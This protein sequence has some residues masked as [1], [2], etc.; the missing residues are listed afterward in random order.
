MADTNFYQ[1]KDGK[2]TELCKTCLTAHINNWEPET[3]L[4]LLEKFDVP[5]I[6][7]EWN[8]LRDRAY[9]KDP[10]KFG[11]MSVFGKYLSKMKLNQWK[12]FTWA[13]TEKL[14][15]EAE[16]KAKLYGSGTNQAKSDFDNIKE[17]YENGEISEAQYQTYAELNK[18]EKEFVFDEVTKQV[19]EKG[20]ETTAQY[21]INNHPFE[22]V[23]LPDPTAEL[24]QEDKIYLAMKWGQ[25]YSAADWIKLEEQYIDYEKSFDLHNA[26][27]I[28][29]TKELCKLD[30]KGDQALDTGDFDSYSKIARAKDTLRKSLKFTEAQRKEDKESEFSCYGQI[31][32]FAEENNDEDYIPNIDLSVDR[33]MVDI[34]IRDMKNYTKTLIEDDPAVFKM[35]EQY[36]KK[37]EILAEQERD[38]EGLEDGEVYELSDEEMSEYNQNIEQQRAEDDH[39][40]KE[41]EEDD[42]E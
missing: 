35:I 36:I 27:L 42:D 28:R 7:A 38:A 20:T 19:V 4:W 16:E 23:D 10:V 33:D 8:V 1:Y 25:L 9:N 41:E 13:D 30:L 34:D 11:P 31:V 26:D 17:A 15:L 39:Y 3:F 21:P 6:E 22:V 12:N 24:T 18:P 37:R 40:E 32:S 14:K 29:G 2:K 5:Y